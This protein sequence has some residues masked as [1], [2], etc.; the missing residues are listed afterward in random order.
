MSKP[1]IGDVYRMG[2]YP[3]ADAVIQRINEN[4][5]TVDLARP[6]LYANEYGAP[7]VG[8]ELVREVRLIGDWPC[9]DF[10]RVR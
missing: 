4:T 2:T 8:V 7:L 3:F 10:G 1:K 5:G 9:I 6:Y